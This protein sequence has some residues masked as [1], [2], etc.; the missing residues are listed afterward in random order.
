MNNKVCQLLPGLPPKAINLR[1]FTTEKD[2]N[3]E[4]FL[5]LSVSSVLSVVNSFI[6]YF[7]IGLLPRNVAMLIVILFFFVSCAV[8]PDFEHPKPSVPKSWESRLSATDKEADTNLVNWW[9]TFNDPVL[10]SLIE[11]SID[12]NLD[13]QQASFRVAQARSTVGV[14]TAG[15]FPD[16]NAQAALTRRHNSLATSPTNN[17]ANTALATSIPQSSSQAVGASSTSPSTH[18]ASNLF[19]TGLSTSWSAD[20]FGQI[21][22]N[23]ETANANLQMTVE[24]KRGIF[25]TLVSDVAINYVNLRAFQRQVVIAK[26]QLKIQ[27]KTASIM[28][29]RFEAGRAT[30]LDTSNANA[31][32]ANTRAQIPTYEAAAQIAMQNISVLLGREPLALQKTLEPVAVIPNIP[33]GIPIGIPS[34]ILRR[35]P[36]ILKAEAQ[37]H[38]ATAQI[39]VATA[40][41][42]PKF[43]LTG[44]AGFSGAHA[45]DIGTPR[46]V[47]WTASPS[48]SLPIFTA[49]RITWNIKLQE[50]IRDEKFAFYQKTLLTAFK[51]VESSLVNY[52][53]EQERQKYLQESVD[54]YRKSV[55]VAMT[56]YMAGKTDFLSVVVTQQ[57]LFN[58][59]NSLTQSKLN[60]ALYLISLYKALGGGWESQIKDYKFDN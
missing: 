6:L 49:G 54:N 7:A 9:R 14:M 48:L 41:L 57:S 17:S 56:L 8:G 31:Q 12:S 33:G 10:V 45:S 34:D 16:L 3:T 24:D 60:V 23:I 22:R 4:R 5:H 50:N 25:L 40:D 55:E 21:R 20:V 28:S 44:T 11:Q 59:E 2:E 51:E 46:S 35:R 39:G 43:T 1:I 36:D 37:L 42:Y 53:A 32:A 52:G 47:F 26:E 13:L 30:S 15:L 58:S 19:Q 18:S 29:K 27:E 38:A